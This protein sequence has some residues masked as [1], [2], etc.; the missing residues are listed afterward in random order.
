MPLDYSTLALIG[1]AARLIKRS[2]YVTALTGAGVSVESGIR[3]FRGP[4]GIWTEFGEPPMDG[5]RSFEDNPR[6]YWEEMMSPVRRS[7]FGDSFSEAKPNSG[8]M[9]FA[10]LEAMGI[11]KSLVT[12][13]IDGLHIE[14][15]SMKVLEIHGNRFKLRCVNCNTRFP[16]VGFDLST[17]PPK[18][19]E[20]GGIVK[21]DIVMFGEPIPSDVL[22]AC[23]AEAGRSDCMIVAGT[24]A[25]VYPAASLP[26]IVKDRE[27]VIIEINPLESDLSKICDVVVRASSGEAV[28]ALVEALKRLA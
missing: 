2:R 19:P 5:Y 3:P 27:G 15:G 17:L 13:N 21:D 8:H 6:G 4:G 10:E 11:L 24:S 25:V 14:A 9:A 1:E 22:V 7:R 28:P 12:Q 26:L 16:K 20:C 18:C 23:Q